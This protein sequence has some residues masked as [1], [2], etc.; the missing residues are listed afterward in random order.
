[1]KMCSVAMAVAALTVAMPLPALASAPL[2]AELQQQKEVRGKVVDERGEPMIG[3]TVKLKGSSAGTVTDLNGD[4]VLP[5]GDRQPIEL[6]Y[7]GYLP[8]TVQG[9]AGAVL[10]VQMKPDTKAMDEVLVIG[11]GTVRKRD[12]L[13]A[14]SQVKEA[15]IKLSPVM[16]AMEGLA[17][18]VAGLDITRTSGAAGS[19]PTL[20]LRGYRSLKS[21]SGE[22]VS[23]C[24]PL[25][26]VDGVPGS[27][28]NLNPN[29]I[30][31]IEVL[32]DASSTA[33]Y[34]A[35][36][37]NGVII[38]TTRQGVKGK[39]Q[40]DFNAYVGINAFPSYPSTLTG[41]KWVDFVVEGYR[42]SSRY[43][44]SDEADIVNIALLDKLQNSGNAMD[45]YNSGQ[46]VNWRDE[47]LQTGVQENYNIS[48]R[49]GTDRGQSY[50]SLGYQ[51]EK[52]L[53][54][55][56]KAQM[57]SFRAGSNYQVN[58]MLKLG[59]QSTVA[60]KNRDNR[61]SRLSRVL[62]QIPLGQVWNDDGSLRIHPIEGMDSYI[63]IMA[64]D[65]PYAY[66]SNSRS[67]SLTVAP[68]I[69]LTPLKGLSLRSL[70][71]ASASF[72]RHGKWD[73]MDTYQELVGTQTPNQRSAEYS[74]GNGWGYTW[75][76]V[77]TYK[78]KPAEEHDVTLTAVTE[79]GQSHHESGGGTSE[80]IGFDQ[81]KYYNLQ[82]G[83]NQKVTTAFSETSKMSYALRASYSFMGRYLL[84]GSVRWDGASQLYKDKRWCAFPAVSAGWRISDEP[85]MQQAK[86]VSN[87]KLR[88]GYGVTGNAN[89]KAY[90]SLQGVEVS[91]THVTLGEK[92]ALLYKLT[93]TVAN[94]D[95]TWEKSYNWNI[96][97]DYGFLGGRIDGSIEFYD[98]D[99]KGVLYT[100]RLPTGI[101]SY[102]AQLP[103]VM[104]SN[105][106]RI[107]NRGAELTVNSRNI[108]NSKFTWT[109]TVTFSTNKEELKEINVGENEEVVKSLVSENIFLG[110]ATR[111]FYYYKKLGIWQSDE[112][113]QAACFGKKPGQVKLD[114][115]GMVYD[116]DYTYI[117]VDADGNEVGTRK[118]AYY[119]PSEDNEDG[120]HNYYTANS[121]YTMSQQTDRQIIGKETPDWTLGFQNQFTWNGFDLSIMMQV[122]WGQMAQGNL[123]S[124]V[125]STNQPETYDYW[126]PTNATNAYPSPFEGNS[127]DDLTALSYVNTSFIKV[128][129]ITLGY[130]LPHKLLK[131]VGMTNAR[132]YGTIT[133]PL[134]ISKE[135]KLL[136]GM[137]PENPTDQFPLY[138]TLV[139][140]VNVSF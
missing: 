91:A 117:E 110:E 3:V 8:M 48:A 68:Y 131:R 13:G 90:S 67:F 11:Y 133:N 134:I 37:A 74:T 50:M 87:L 31:S 2:P 10:Q 96:G 7:V 66:E 101:G 130:T 78:F 33:I 116:P 107:R 119:R 61:N 43:Q 86:W 138:K 115:P 56:D 1:M 59:F 25:F 65:V 27:I 6:S 71:N 53:Y 83:D 22:W 5:A 9:R 35:E 29:D 19:S 94:H 103:Y 122:R 44:E 4:F 24:S 92:D 132:I 54:R 102:T 38:V 81:F 32:K 73:G 85:F 88:V 135:H 39:T 126:T 140:G 70:L 51:R 17:G 16:N 84:Q 15:D 112:A 113:D 72:S 121:T 139:F 79:Y 23:D 93:Q 82:A 21:P 45:A 105:I 40:V 109:S 69:E 123:L 60:Y 34:G 18:K 80:E 30:E 127:T 120:T 14:I 124:R 57:L 108:V 111:P 75:Q 129:N 42:N 28:D 97:L 52:G 89:I 55:K 62:N 114:V 136:K 118:G 76:N 26:I 36:G 64:D 58:R 47:L 128:K 104:V 46:W 100:R 41:Q 137:D 63:N 20:L 98:T 125:N 106:A 95:L 77:L 12:A 99:T 49:G